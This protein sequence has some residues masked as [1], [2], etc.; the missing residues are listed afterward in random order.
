M[1]GKPTASDPT[2]SRG[3]QAQAE[4]LEMLTFSPEDGRI[5]LHGKRMMMLDVSSFGSLREDL[6]SR[7]GPHG[8]RSLLTRIGYASG[9][10]DANLIRQRWP[11]DYRQHAHIG[12]H[13]HRLEG[14][15]QIEPV[16]VNTNIE[17]GHFDGEYRWRHSIEDDVNILSHG[18][19][20][21]PACWME[22]G[23]AT[24]YVSRMC[25][26]LILFREVECRSMGSQDCRVVA[27]PAGEWNDIA[28]DLEYLGLPSPRKRSRARTDP[29]APVTM[30]PT[31]DVDKPSRR[32]V[33]SVQSGER[34]IV[35]ESASITAALHLLERVAP[36]TATVLLTGESGVGK[37]L[38]AR[39]LHRL[40]PRASGP[41]VAVNCAAIPETLI[42]AELFGVERGAFTGA[43]QSRA[44]R[45]ERASGGTLFLDEI[46]TLSAVAQTKL[47][48]ALQEGEVERVGG[49]KL[50]SVD[51]RVVAASNV[52]LRQ[53]VEQGQFREDLF[54]RLNVFPVEL[55]PLRDRRDDIPRLVTHF[56][57]RFNVSHGKAVTRLTQRALQALLTFRYPGNV[58]ELEKIIERAVILADGDI[59]DLAH[60]LSGD[61]SADT[62]LLF[63]GENGRLV[64]NRTEARAS[65]A[66][67]VDL[68]GVADQ[69][70]KECESRNGNGLN[71]VGSELLDRVARKAVARTGGNVSAAARLLGL[72]RHQLEYRLSRRP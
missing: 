61:Q 45:F 66:D 24:G 20:T 63:V 3:A 19:G 23:Y 17:T 36:T 41:F 62:S 26:Q 49:T 52:S 25:D 30:L 15:A 50:V 53:A 46:A 31:E 47:L 42:E 40:C 48:R 70:L 13:L 21:E 59:I 18:L 14:I 44:G 1:T 27:A 72:K 16:R 7:L 12:P 11:D 67:E 54:F 39:A 60:V 6:I 33:R 58:R 8:A 10:S 22:V 71:H 2:D 29:R 4:L 5:W 64:G 37:E 38:F 65:T 57:R 28:E 56:L 32:P 55:P 9:V 68:D 43:V 34:P 69:L 51:V 35:G